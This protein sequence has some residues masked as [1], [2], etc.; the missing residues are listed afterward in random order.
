MT[1]ASA[2]QCDVSEVATGR[3]G[4]QVREALARMGTTE[5]RRQPNERATCQVKQRADQTANKLF[6]ATVNFD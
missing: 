3:R 5:S 2:S 1:S 4:R 6:D